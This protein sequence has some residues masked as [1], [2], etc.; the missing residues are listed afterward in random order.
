MSLA[1]LHV[2]FF[3]EVLGMETQ[4]DVALPEKPRIEEQYREDE[5]VA[6]YPVL[7]LLHG[8]TDDHTCWQRQ[9]SVERYAEEYGVALVMPCVN[10]SWYTDMHLGGEKWSQY[11]TFVTEELPRVCRN[12]FPHMSARREDTFV[13]GM[14]MGGYG[15]LKLGLRAAEQFSYVAPLSGALDMA[16]RVRDLGSSNAAY[17]ADIFGS[18][19]EMAGGRDDLMAA[20][21]E[22]AASGKPKPKIYIWCGTEDFLYEHNTAM[23]DHLQALGYD[24]TYEEGPGDH[25]WIY[26]DDIVQ[27]VFEWLPLERR[28]VE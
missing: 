19:E 17:F 24:L 22:L 18:P 13:C 10:L 21:A 4:M 5:P 2:S 8:M 28:K 3:S 7:Y 14:S 20:A 16:S 15:T 9:T 6:P 27:R 12:L 26:W 25:R 1:L 23:R 11:F